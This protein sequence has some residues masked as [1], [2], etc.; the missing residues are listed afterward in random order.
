VVLSVVG[1]VNVAS[2]KGGYLPFRQPFSGLS[3]AGY[4]DG[5]IDEV[6]ELQR[7]RT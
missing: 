1:F 3:E 2:A 4:V 5:R 7:E 6:P